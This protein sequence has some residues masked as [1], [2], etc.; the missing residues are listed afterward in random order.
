[1]SQNLQDPVLDLEGPKSERKKVR[2][3]GSFTESPVTTIPVVAMTPQVSQVG[4]VLMTDNSNKSGGSGQMIRRRTWPPTPDS[5]G[6]G[7]LEID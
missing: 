2:E 7:A 6:A 5:A 3:P 4:E 1:M